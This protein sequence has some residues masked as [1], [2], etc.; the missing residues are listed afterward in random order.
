MHHFSNPNKCAAWNT[1]YEGLEA[2]CYL[3]GKSKYG[4]VTIN[5][6]HYLAHRIIYSMYH[7]VI[8]IDVAIDHIDGNGYN[9][10]IHNLRTATS[11]QNSANVRWNSSNTSG[12]K[13]V[14]VIKLK[15][16]NRYVARIRVNQ[17]SKHLGMFTTPEEAH[18]VY[19]RAA[20]LHF[21]EYFNAGGQI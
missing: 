13:G 15:Q 17:Q 20:K 12:F 6:T 7:G 8:G 19:V 11:Q 4:Q 18:E 10:A 21:G 3:Q 5:N 1:Q 14:S 16:G 9:N 2:I